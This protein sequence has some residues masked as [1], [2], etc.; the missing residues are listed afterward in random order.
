[1]SNILNKTAT[2]V[3]VQLT[4]G[5]GYEHPKKLDNSKGFMPVT[6][7]QVGQTEYGPIFSVT[8]Y[9]EQNGDL[10]TDPEM[11]FLQSKAGGIMP[12]TYEQGGLGIY[13]VAAEID[14]TTIKANCRLLK[15]LAAFA[16]T[17]MKNIKQQQRACVYMRVEQ[18]FFAFFSR[19][20]DKNDVPGY[21]FQYAEQAA[22]YVFSQAVRFV[23]NIGPAAF[24]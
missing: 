20:E 16:N 10:V 18:V 24:A 6:V 12:L 19:G 9:Y 3:F 11:T 4:A 23:D 22:D 21:A 15:E 5:V 2:A 14:G 7:E 1:M 13:Q 8:H 17:W